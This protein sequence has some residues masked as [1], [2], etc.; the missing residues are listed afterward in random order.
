MKDR[1]EEFVRSHREEFD[2]LEPRS[3]MWENIEQMMDKPSQFRDRIAKRTVRYYIIRVAGIAAIFIF[4][5]GVQ[6]FYLNYK[7]AHTEIPELREAEMYY[8]G[9]IK[10][11]L[12]EAKPILSEYPEI[13]E[14][15]NSDLSELDSVYKDL[16][17]DLKDNVANQEVI[18]AMIDNYRLRIGILEE[19]LGF[20]EEKNS[21]TTKKPEY[22][23]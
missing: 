15:L 7:N 22:E 16:K 19:M 13:Q 10:Q 2:I 8:T 18:E 14:K 21:A 11:K 23:L 17:K 12:I 20:L 9:L 6:R 5:L 1:L 4:S 3:D